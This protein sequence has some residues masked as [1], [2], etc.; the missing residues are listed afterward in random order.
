MKI[1]PIQPKGY[2]G[3]ESE[4]GYEARKRALRELARAKEKL[5]Q[6]KTSDFPKDYYEKSDRQ[7]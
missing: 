4:K 2:A 5:Q 7:K 1:N 3:H 6:K